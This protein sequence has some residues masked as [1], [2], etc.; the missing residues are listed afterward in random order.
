MTLHG[1]LSVSNVRLTYFMNKCERNTKQISCCS[2]Q[3]LNRETNEEH[4]QLVMND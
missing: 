4:H 1:K 3:M 2:S